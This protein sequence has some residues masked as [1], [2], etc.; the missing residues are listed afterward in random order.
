[1]LMSERL[2][3][4]VDP[5]PPELRRDLAL[6]LGAGGRRGQPGELLLLL[7]GD[8]LRV[9]GS[10]NRLDSWDALAGG[11]DHVVVGVLGAEHLQV[12]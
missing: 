3:Q 4:G 6:I 2:L 10:E 1:M 7:Q 9:H 12:V 8:A 11:C 5:C